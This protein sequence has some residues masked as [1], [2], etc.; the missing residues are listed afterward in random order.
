MVSFK[1]AA[2]GNTPPTVATPA[3]A[4]PNPVTGTTANLSVLGAD[5]GGEANLVY[6]WATTGTPPAAV[7]FSANGTNAA[8]NAIATFTKA[9]SYSIQVTIKDQG[10]LTVTS[11][12]NVTVNQTLISI[13]VVPPSASV[14]AGKTPGVHAA[15]LE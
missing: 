13:N 8:R 10:N 4:T 14:V 11:S 5:D 12:V 7:T 6:T 1:A 15:A 3:A 2:S 9:G